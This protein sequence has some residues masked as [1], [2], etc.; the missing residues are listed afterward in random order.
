LTGPKTPS[1]SLST[2]NENCTRE[3]QELCELLE[4]LAIIRLINVTQ[5]CDKWSIIQL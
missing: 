2:I 1:T 5:L 3:K 4:R